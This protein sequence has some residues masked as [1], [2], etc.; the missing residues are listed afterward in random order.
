MG[1][2]ARVF[3]RMRGDGPCP[4]C[5]SSEI[6]PVQKN[7]TVRTQYGMA[8]FNLFRCPK[9]NTLMGRR[10]IVTPCNSSEKKSEI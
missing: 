7:V 6:E 8:V 10:V 2:L 1:E 4:V 5:K 3:Y 9:C